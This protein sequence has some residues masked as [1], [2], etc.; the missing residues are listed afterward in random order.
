MNK[1]DFKLFKKI[2]ELTTKRLLLRKIEAKDLSDVYDYAS[3]P[4]VSKY[5][6]WSYHRSASYTK[7][8]LKFIDKLYKKGDFFDWGIVFDGKLIGTVGFSRIDVF[9]NAAEIGY[10]LNQKYWGRGIAAEAVGAILEFGFERL[11]LDRIEAIF[12]SDNVQS[13]R[14]LDKCGLHLYKNDSMIIKGETRN[15]Q[16]FYITKD[17]YE[18]VINTNKI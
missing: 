15:V 3:N 6:L 10:V 11:A 12:I 2:P 7:K 13:K 17:E 18:E 5:L 8:Y 16:I 4:E 9:N 14:V 1:E